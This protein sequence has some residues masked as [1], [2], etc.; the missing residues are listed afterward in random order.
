MNTQILSLCPECLY[1]QAYGELPQ[2]NEYGIRHERIQRGSSRINEFFEYIDLYPSD[3]APEKYFSHHPCDCCLSYLY[4][5][6][7]DVIAHDKV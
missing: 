3:E 6:R 7:Y 4:G 1:Y 5:D 2:E